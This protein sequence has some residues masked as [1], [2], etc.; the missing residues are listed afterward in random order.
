MPDSITHDL[1]IIGGGPAGL[2]SAIYAARASLKPL[3]FAGALPGG[4]LMLTSDVENYP[5]FPDGV[6]GPELMD[7]WRAQ[8]KRF[9]ATL[10]NENVTEIDTSAQPFTVQAGDQTERAHSVIIATGANAKWL[11]LKNEQRLIGRGVHTCAACDGFMYSGKHVVVVGGGDTAM[12]ETLTLAKLADRVTIVHRRD[13]LRASKIMADRAL[14]NP[15]ITFAWNSTVEDVL[16]ENVVAGVRLKDTKTG[17]ERELEADGLFIAI[18]YTP[19]TA[20]L[21]NQLELRETGYL[22]V[23]DRTRTSVDGVF[24]AG[25]VEDY[26]YRQAI[27][28]A[29]GGCMAAM[30]A[31]KWLALTER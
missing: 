9:G 3:V 19:N 27:T 2:T 10:V 1:I 7:R 31:E 15:K 25:D 29:S 24:A 12:E 18:G 13:E 8:A 28:A 26:H 6:L 21:K 30:D 23:H 20:F 4:Q 17:E 22:V 5:G 11:G 16:G 14:K